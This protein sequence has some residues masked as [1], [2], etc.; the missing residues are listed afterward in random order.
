MRSQVLNS[1]WKAQA[2][3]ACLRQYRLLIRSAVLPGA[4]GGAY[5]GGSFIQI[6]LLMGG[7]LELS[8][9]DRGLLRRSK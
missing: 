6:S 7:F 5:P 9:K 2:D 1:K 4:S 8:F 3:S